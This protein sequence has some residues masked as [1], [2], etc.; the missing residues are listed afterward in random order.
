MHCDF[1]VTVGRKS[2]P[3]CFTPSLA[4][5]LLLNFQSTLFNVLQQIEH[6]GKSVVALYKVYFSDDCFASRTSYFKFRKKTGPKRENGVSTLINDSKQQ[7]VF[8][9]SCSSSGIHR[10]TV[11]PHGPEPWTE[12][13]PL[14]GKVLPKAA[15][16]GK[17]P[18]GVGKKP[19]RLGKKHGA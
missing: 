10:Y 11:R 8:N 19:G 13:P 17:K 6:C 7:C 3:L 14:K 5:A 15:R 4:N 12:S 2:G 1:C 9:L 18:G 16:V